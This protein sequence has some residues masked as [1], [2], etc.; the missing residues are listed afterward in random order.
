MTETKASEI[1]P[2]KKTTT[3]KDTNSDRVVTS[4]SQ[5]KEQAGWK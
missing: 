1:N 5:G 2:T 3:F 4:G